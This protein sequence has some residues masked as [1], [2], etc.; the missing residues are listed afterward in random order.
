[1]A[2]VGVHQ[3]LSNKASLTSGDLLYSVDLLNIIFFLT[4]EDDIA[5]GHLVLLYFMVLETRRNVCG[6]NTDDQQQNSLKRNPKP[7]V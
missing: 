2:N 6:G 7:V 1:M 5:E 4:C 3:H